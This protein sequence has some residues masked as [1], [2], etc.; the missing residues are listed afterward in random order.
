[1]Y[2][3]IIICLSIAICA[4]LSGMLI[5]QIAAICSVKK[6]FD[7]PDGRKIHQE[8]ISR[9]GGF[10]FAPV[11][12][13][14]FALLT[15]L[16]FVFGRPDIV[17]AAQSEASVLSLSFCSLLILYVMGIADDLVGV[18]F[19]SKFV[20]Q[21]L[22]GVLLAMGG[23]LIDNFYG[24]FGVGLLPQWIAYPFTVVL[25]VFIINALNLID[26]IDGLASGLSVVACLFYGFIFFHLQH[27]L[28]A[29]LAF[30]TLGV[31]IPFF[32]YNVFGKAEEGKKI[33]MGDTGS[34]TIGLILS[35]LSIKLAQSIPADGTALFNPLMVAF[36]PLIVPCF[37]A[38]R[39][40]FHRI[41]NGR[42]PFKPDKNHI[43]H[44]LLAIGLS[45][46][47]A[48]IILVSV[49]IVYLVGNIV[50]SRY[51]NATFLLIGDLVVWIAGTVCL[52]HAMVKRNNKLTVTQKQFNK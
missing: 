7:V 47:S 15:G 22:C 12:F 14:V 44:K 46:R 51:V 49:A 48:R 43:H 17:M 30:G 24:V 27:Y 8:N 4:C 6:L 13:F 50:L 9:L 5:P 38:A 18:R 26:G 35:L 19:R 31:L 21:I 39:V 20:M 36:S 23:I 11:I 45:Q 3:I 28:F 16:S 25:I 41:C 52:T 34:L 37:D 10:A 33:F 29:M 1:M 2:W 32:Y 40:F 42:H